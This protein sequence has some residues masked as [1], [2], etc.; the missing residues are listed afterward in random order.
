[1]TVKATSQHVEDARE[2]EADL[3]FAVVTYVGENSLYYST[4][5]HTQGHWPSY[6]PFVPDCPQ[7]G[8]VRDEGLGYFEGHTD[9]DIEYSPEAVAQTFLQQNSLPPLFFEGGGGYTKDRL[10]D[11]LEIETVPRSRDELRDRLADIAGVDPGEDEGERELEGR[12][13]DEFTRFELKAASRDL[14]EGVDDIS[15]NSGKLDFAAFLA[16]HVD[17]GAFDEHGLYEHIREVNDGSD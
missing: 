6:S 2:G 3:V 10:L 16:S 12:L 14:R 4:A 9:F 17:E 7:V 5:L 8:L 13:V 1:M 15:L 11:F